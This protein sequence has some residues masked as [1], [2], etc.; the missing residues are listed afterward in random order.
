MEAYFVNKFTFVF[1][2]LGYNPV[3]S[4]CVIVLMF[5]TSC[6][7]NFIDVFIIVMSVAMSERFKQFNQKLLSVNGKVGCVCKYFQLVESQGLI[8]DYVVFQDMP[9]TF[10]RTMRE[11]Y[12]VLSCLTKLLDELLS[13]IVLLSF[14]NNLYFICLQ[15][16]NSLK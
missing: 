11:T 1:Q 16:L 9:T 8:K 7:W 3:L 2:S 13:P 6:A 14:A 12:N 15:L 5:L 4:V 10:W